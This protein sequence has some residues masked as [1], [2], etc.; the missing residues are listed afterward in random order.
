[1]AQKGV[2]AITGAPTLGQLGKKGVEDDIKDAKTK[3]REFL[4]MTPTQQAEVIAKSNQDIADRAT[5][6]Y[7]D[8]VG[9]SKEMRDDTVGVMGTIGGV[10]GPLSVDMK[11]GVVTD[12]LTGDVIGGRDAQDARAAAAVSEYGYDSDIGKSQRGS[13]GTPGP[14]TDTQLGVGAELDI[15]ADSPDTTGSVGGGHSVGGS[16]APD[17]GDDTGPDEGS[18]AAGA[19][20]AGAFKGGLI[21]KR[22]QK[23][24]KKRSGLAS[25]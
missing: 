15:G 20:A 9:A 24:K 7:M 11:T 14:M 10:T 3:A 5:A 25:R 22:K 12:P 1:M 8:A 18:A 19:E 17:A 16:D 6:G 4:A 21:P 13:P 23:K 2:S